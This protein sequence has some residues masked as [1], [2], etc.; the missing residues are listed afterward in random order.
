MDEHEFRRIPVQYEDEGGHWVPDATAISEE[1]GPQGWEAANGEPLEVP[2][3]PGTFE[4]VLRRS[5]PSQER[6]LHG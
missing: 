5:E 3:V 1:Y 6:R 4:W 2:D